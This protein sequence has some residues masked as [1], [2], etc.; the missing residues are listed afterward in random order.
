MNDSISV[1]IPSYNSSETIEYTIDGILSQKFVKANEI[2]IVDSSGDEKFDAVIS[3]Y[4][5]S[6]VIRFI[7]STERLT[8][9]KARNIGSKQAMGNLLVFLDSDVIPSPTLLSIYMNAF[10]GG[11]MAGGGGIE[12]PASQFNKVIPTAQY[13]LQCNEYLPVGGKRIKKFLSGC[14]FFCDNQRFHEIGGFPELRASEDVLFG[15][16][17]SRT[18][19]IWFIPDASVSH[20]FREDWKSFLSNQRLLGKYVGIYRN[21]ISRLL[22]KNRAVLM[23]LFPIFYAVK[24]FRIVPRIFGAGSLH[25]YEFVKVIP[26]F[27]FGLIFWTFGFIAGGM[28]TN[29]Q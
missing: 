20:I 7:R 13:Y 22:L 2:I 14:N 21:G 25:V 3:K 18:T 11:C 27:S 19:E 4:K 24:Y 1:I 23:M 8:P 6:T 16:N 12:L 10:E 15:L 26:I 28:D 5:S 29:E 9:A 17:L